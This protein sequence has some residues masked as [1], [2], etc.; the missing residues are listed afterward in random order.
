V[1]NEPL[2]QP[3]AKKLILHILD[4][5]KV[6]FSRHAFEEMANDDLQNSDNRVEVRM[7]CFDCGAEMEMR[8]ENFQ[9]DAS[10][11]PGMVLENVEVSRC[12]ACGEWEVAIPRIE[13]LHQVIAECV[14]RKRGRLIGAE[15]R[16]L[17][18]YIGW[19]ATDFAERMGTTRETVSRWE[20]GKFPIGPQADRLLRM[21]VVNTPPV[22]DYSAD[23]LREIGDEAGT[24]TQVRLAADA[25]GWRPMAA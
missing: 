8:T 3:E 22:S 24:P 4:E 13:Q 11:L 18:K 25:S 9:Y 5:G 2:T 15:V 21:L 14:I 23:L 1:L 20:T 16:F 6:S 7:K 10:G 19:S 17:R 12:P